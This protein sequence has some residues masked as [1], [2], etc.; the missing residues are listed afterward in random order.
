MAYYFINTNAN[1]LGD[2]SPHNK[3]IE[4]GF[5]FTGGSIEYGEKLG[6]LS[7][8]DICLMYANRIGVVAIGR[9]HEAWDGRTYTSP[10][11]YVPPYYDREYRI[12]VDWYLDLRNDPISPTTLIRVLGWN[13]RFSV[14]R[15]RNDEAR[16]AELVDRIEKDHGVAR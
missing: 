15:V 13:P 10:I 7:R 6:R 5:A 9:V 2:V 1:S 4:S 8:G 14:Q 11:V 16:I 3:W 12:K